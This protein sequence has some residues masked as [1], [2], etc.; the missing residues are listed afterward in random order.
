MIQ[1]VKNYKM[2]RKLNLSKGVDARIRVFGQDIEFHCG[3]A[4]QFMVAALLTKRLCVTAEKANR[5]LL[6]VKKLSEEI[7]ELNNINEG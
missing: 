7:A 6:K 4:R 3:N 2:V 1:F 5:Q